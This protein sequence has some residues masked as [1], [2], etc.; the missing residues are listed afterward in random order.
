MNAKV[1]TKRSAPARDPLKRY[2][3]KRDFAKTPE[4]AGEV[5]K[6]AADLA[7]VIQKHAATRLHYD[8]RLEL[9]G[10]MVS[11][12]VPKGPSYDPK[13][14]RIAMHVEDHPIA[15]NAFEGTIP[16]NQ[17]GAGE[18]IIWDR[19]TWVPV[20]DP[21]KGLDEGKLAFTLH[22]QKL[23]GLWE[24]VRIRKPGERQDPWLLFKKHDA[25]ARSKLEYDVV[26]ALP[27]SVVAK[28]LGRVSLPPARSTTARS[29]ATDAM[30]RPAALDG[31]VKAALPAKLAPQLA[32][33]AQTLPAGDWVYEIKFDGYR[34][35]ARIENGEARLFTRRGH[36]WTQKMPELA[37]ALAQL[38]VSS[39]WLD[40]EIVVIGDD[41][42]PDFNALQNVFQ[43][44]HAG[45]IEYFV[46]D[47]PYLDGYDL[48]RVSLRE[49]R[50]RLK[51]LLD[52]HPADHVRFSVD[53]DADP[54]SILQSAEKMK[55]EGL[56]AK[57][58]D[59]PYVSERT[60]TWLKLKCR[61]RQEFVVVGYCDRGGEAGAAEIGSLLLGV[62]ASGELKFVGGVGAGWNAKT[63]AGL[64][65]RLVSLRTATSPFTRSEAVKRSR[66]ARRAAGAERWVKPQL[67]AEVSFAGWTPDDQIRHAKF[68]GLRLDKP[69]REVVREAP[70]VVSGDALAAAAPRPISGTKVTHPQR[71]I[72]PSS[73]TTKL[74]LV[75]YY[76][77]VAEWMV[78]HLKGRPCSLVRG[79]N[80]IGGQLFYQKHADTLRIAGVRSLDPALWPGHDALLEI[81]TA[82]AI[83]GA[84][85]LNVIEF[86]TWNAK[87]RRIDTPDRIIFDLDP[88][89]QVPWERVQ[90]AALLLRAFLRELGLEGWLKT[91]G[92]KGLHIVVP[93]ATRYD[94]DTARD[95]SEAVVAQLARVVPDRF[96]A[97]SGAANRIGRIYV[98]YV[99]NAHGATTVAA[100]SA[101]ARPGLGVSM[102]VPWEMLESLKGGDQW[103]VAT[104]REHLSFH[105][106]D[107]WSD[108]W[109]ARQSLASTMKLLK[110]NTK[111]R[112]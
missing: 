68:E 17:Y 97:K 20:G 84:A 80:G 38:P 23:A 100:Y 59:A 31:A 87:A 105:R 52:R 65:Q 49:R 91:S 111:S 83:V 86:H 16:R 55:L 33:P 67:V 25:Y 5:G 75:R 42:T 14:K 51:A 1:S 9:D 37:K 18:V 101:R 63:A 103:T 61:Q 45:G 71:V 69:A 27:D 72:D 66:W 92:G 40:G 99:R 90:E 110:F 94:W 93:I 53:F 62:Y 50:A 46:F 11:W 98:D 4:P 88:G 26:S 21:R 43:R 39:A 77:S 34:L 76:E 54:I 36:D 8:L 56:I 28:P 48:R 13:D 32:S 74:D 89:E 78:P 2:R 24:L 73:G 81:P 85:Q 58:A 96:V 109:S 108:Y 79:P 102:P 95:L 22:G 112:R 3:T 35:L 82:R 30:K 70:S 47:V 106:N 10:V 104:A 107:P 7:F 19:G 29:A 12:A 60:V 6:T 15:Y 57:R 41:G 64:K 44:P